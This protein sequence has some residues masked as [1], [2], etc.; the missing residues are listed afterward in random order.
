M[1]TKYIIAGLVV[2]AVVAS[3]FFL[4]GGNNKLSGVRDLKSRKEIES[5]DDTKFFTNND[6]RHTFAHSFGLYIKNSEI[7]GLIIQRGTGFKIVYD[8]I[9]G[10]EIY[11]QGSLKLQYNIET[12]KWVHVCFY[13]SDSRSTAYLYIDGKLVR[14]LKM[15]GDTNLITNP[16]IIGDNSGWSKDSAFI[17]NY[18]HHNSGALNDPAIMKLAQ[19]FSSSYN[20]KTSDI[21]DFDIKLKKDEMK[22]ANLSF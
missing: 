8:N 15:T 9:H 13:A 2:L 21:Y 12:N 22:I 16:I 18:E 6:E 10:L 14:S 4:S 7:S 20:T 3:V 17:A 5:R 1:Q 11:H 19:K